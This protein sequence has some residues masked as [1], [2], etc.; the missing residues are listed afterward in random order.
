[1]FGV[2]TP[3]SGGGGASSSGTVGTARHSSGATRIRKARA[4]AWDAVRRA[5]AEPPRRRPDG[6]PVRIVLAAMDRV[7]ECALALAAAAHDGARVP[8]PEL[9][10]CR[11]TLKASFARTASWLLG[12]SAPARGPLLATATALDPGRE[13]GVDPALGL[14]TA[15]AR[16]VL[17]ALS[18]ARAGMMPLDSTD[19]QHSGGSAPDDG[20]RGR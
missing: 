9:A 7:S 1:M 4:Q 10:A 18:A 5:L 12:T 13:P 8:G 17:D 14:V 15:E 20:R 16:H 6:Q 11:A 2:T 3:A 19:D